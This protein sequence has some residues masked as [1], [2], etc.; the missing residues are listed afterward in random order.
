MRDQAHGPT[1]RAVG[2]AIPFVTVRT[3]STASIREASH[4][5]P[6]L[7]VRDGLDAPEG[8]TEISVGWEHLMVTKPPFSNKR[9]TS[10]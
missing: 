1:T 9:G 5:N 4:C 10:R 8:Y 3:M 6:L 7:M 2:F